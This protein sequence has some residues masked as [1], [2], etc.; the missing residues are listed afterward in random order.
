M[1]ADRGVR[2][3]SP[4]SP[5]VSKRALIDKIIGVKCAISDHHLPRQPRTSSQYGCPVTRRRLLGAKVGI[6]VFHLGNS[7]NC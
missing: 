2:A 6:S 5:A 7:P 3:A 4:P 1:D